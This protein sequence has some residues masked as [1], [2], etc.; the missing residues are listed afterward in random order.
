MYK[1][2]QIGTTPLKSFL[3]AMSQKYHERVGSINL[4]ANVVIPTIRPTGRFCPLAYHEECQTY[5][6]F[7]PGVQAGKN[8]KKI[9]ECGDG[10]ITLWIYKNV[11][12]YILN[13]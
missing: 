3:A 4:G 6:C 13:G 7:V 5:A 12:L 11:E 8:S 10:C 2:N 1:N 9:E